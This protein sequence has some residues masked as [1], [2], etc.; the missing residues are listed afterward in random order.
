MRELFAIPEGYRLIRA[1]TVAMYVDESRDLLEELRAEAIAQRGS[2]TMEA[3][4]RRL[5][6][7]LRTIR[8]FAD[9][10]CRG[11]RAT[12]LY[13]TKQDI[14]DEVLIRPTAAARLHYR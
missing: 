10:A 4:I 1:E 5:D 11:G 12:H 13:G 3:R 2:F 7:D 14:S 6:G 8:L 9:T